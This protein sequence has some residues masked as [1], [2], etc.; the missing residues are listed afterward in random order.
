MV[1]LDLARLMVY[2]SIFFSFIFENKF[3]NI[4]WT[5]RKFFT[6]KKQLSEF[7]LKKLPLHRYVKIELNTPFIL[8]Q[9]EHSPIL[10][11]PKLGEP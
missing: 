11:G 3:Y 6:K 4:F 7:I 5:S 1:P 10:V 9:N 8:L 2:N